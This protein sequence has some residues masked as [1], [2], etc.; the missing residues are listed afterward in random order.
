MTVPSLRPADAR[1]WALPLLAC[2]FFAL[3]WLAG[4]TVFWG[5]LT[6]IHHPWRAAAA[7]QLARGSLPLWNPWLY[8]GMPLA[9]QMQGAVW[10]PGTVPF[11]L[12]RFETAVA[13]YHGA[14]YALAGLFAF[15]WLRRGGLGAA[16]CLAGAALF[17]ANGV[18]ASRIPYLNHLST[19]AL[20]PAL[21]LFAHRPAA[22]GLTAALAFLSGY[23]LML[24]GGAVAAFGLTWLVERRAPRPLAWLAAV[25]LAA[26]LSALQ[27]LPAAELAAGSKRGAGLGSAEVLEFGLEPGDLPGFVAPWLAPGGL[28]AEVFWWRSCWLG[29]AASLACLAAFPR[30]RPRLGWA[31]AA[32][33]GGVGLLALGGSNPVSRWLWEHFP[34]LRFVRYPGNTTYLLLPAA[35]LLAAAGLARRR[36]AALGAAL[37]AAELGAYA[38]LSQPLVP[39]GFFGDAGPLV[40]ALQAG[41][42]GHRYLLSPQALEWHRGAGAAPALAAADLKHRLYGLT[43]APFR[44]E[45]VANFGEP[46]VPQPNYDVMDFLY[47]RAGVSDA[48]AYLPWVDAPL[49]LTR[50]PHP[51]GP[52]RYLGRR[53][54]HGY[55]LEGPSSRAY[56][57]PLEDGARIPEGLAPAAELPPLARARPLA[58]ERDGESRW[59]LRGDTPAG[60][61][62]VSEVRYP[63][64]KAWLDGR[65]AATEPAWRAF[66]KVRV[67]EGRWELAFRYAPASWAAGLAATLAVLCACAA[68]WYNAAG[69]LARRA[70]L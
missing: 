53:L 55:R 29:L 42:Q 39:R 16:S 60:W 31:L 10:Y 52:L 44:L 49:L 65:P 6:Y 7:D 70:F 45:A 32:Y 59:R 67:P 54:W 57:L 64:W 48:A 24:G 36:W 1:P 40:R 68:Y 13:L 27:L 12:L 61:V 19:L 20:F 30:L 51:A 62:F 8:L 28:S 18:L 63:G 43:N 15:L 66:Q 4:R 33:L 41:N 47:T 9:A 21:L 58:L 23:P 14:H 11:H 38:F 2:A 56:W 25:G 34:P 3:L 22:L 17:M 50:D 26:G 37:I 46:L 35:A 69:N 5:D